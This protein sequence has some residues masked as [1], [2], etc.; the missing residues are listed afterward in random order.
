MKRNMILA[1][2]CIAMMLSISACSDDGKTLY[3]DQNMKSVT[4]SLENVDVD[5]SENNLM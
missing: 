3:E 2:I 1:V 5:S 4:S